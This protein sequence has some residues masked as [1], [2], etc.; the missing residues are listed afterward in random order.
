MLMNKVFF[1][2]CY[3]LV[4]ASFAQADSLSISRGRTTGDP[5]PDRHEYA[6]TLENRMFPGKEMDGT[7]VEASYLIKS[8]PIGRFSSAWILGLGHVTADV[9]T[10]Y[11]GGTL[12]LERST[13]FIQAGFQIQHTALIPHLHLGAELVMMK[14]IAGQVTLRSPVGR[15][16]YEEGTNLLEPNHPYLGGRAT[17]PVMPRLSIDAMVRFYRF[18]GPGL[19]IGATYDISNL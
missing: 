7:H 3:G 1:V 8:K 6:S 5:V 10:S 11:Q 4:S 15:T 16:Q 12:K 17:Y 2:L 19:F 14:G 18:S 13:T 9:E